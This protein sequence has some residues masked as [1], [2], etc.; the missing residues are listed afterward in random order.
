MDII[1]T[2]GISGSGKTTWAIEWIKNN[3]TYLA[4]NRDSFRAALLK[5]ATDFYKRKDVYALESIVTALH[6]T[7]LQ[8]AEAEGYNIIA[9]NTNLTQK[10]INQYI[11]HVGCRSFSIKLFDCDLEQA[12]KRV[13]VR[14]YSQLINSREHKYWQE[15]QVAYI[16]KQFNQYQQIKQYILNTFPDKLI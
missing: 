7:T 9:D 12:K 10:A 1:I 6:E 3:P 2:C 13:M 15:P 14:D 5:S 8:H 16:E 11:N 4:A